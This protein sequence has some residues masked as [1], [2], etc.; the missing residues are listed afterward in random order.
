LFQLFTGWPAYPCRASTRLR[1]G[2]RRSR[3]RRYAACHA[4]PPICPVTDN[5]GGR[6]RSVTQV[7]RSTVQR[8]D[9]VMYR[10]LQRHRLGRADR[11]R[12]GPGQRRRA[13]VGGLPA[14]AAGGRDRGT[15]R[16]ETCARRAARPSSSRR[17]CR[18]RRRVSR[19]IASWGGVPSA[20]GWSSSG[21]HMPG[22][23]SLASAA[24]P[25]LSE[26]T[27]K[28]AAQRPVKLK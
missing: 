23:A 22:A 2:R 9:L 17:T 28:S 16:P 14:V 8:P 27:D 1:G 25:K 18:T 19:R 6:R 5:I 12:T 21:L 4:M 3:V 20:T 15:R 7:A 13:Q 24:L 10:P 26:G 11:P